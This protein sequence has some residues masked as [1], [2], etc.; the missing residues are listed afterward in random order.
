MSFRGCRAPCWLTFSG[1]R[2]REQRLTAP[3]S[4]VA[5][6]RTSAETLPPTLTLDSRGSSCKTTVSCLLW[7]SA[8]LM[9]QAG[10]QAFPGAFVESFGTLYPHAFLTDEETEAFPWPATVQGPHRTQLCPRSALSTTTC[11]AVLVGHLCNFCQ[12]GS[13]QADN[14]NRAMV[15]LCSSP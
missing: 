15:G 3:W 10:A 12:K 11:T 9:S 4:A 2:G 13:G 1:S 6:E 5:A 7:A 8:S 14:L